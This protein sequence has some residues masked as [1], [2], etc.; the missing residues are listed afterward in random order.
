MAAGEATPGVGQEA[1]P[2]EASDI[3]LQRQV[4]ELR[5]DLLDDREQRI[6]RQLEANGAVL[7]ARG[8][9]VGV[10]G[11]RFYARFR[12]I[13]TVATIGPAL[14]GYVVGNHIQW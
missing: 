12:A 10:G 5:S 4:N 9:V 8:I 6:G 14:L 13:A 1:R 2:V 3:E 7:L 11:L